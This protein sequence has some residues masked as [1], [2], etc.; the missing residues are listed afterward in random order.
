VG[1]RQCPEHK[2]NRIETNV[3]RSEPPSPLESPVHRLLPRSNAVVTYCSLFSGCWYQP[4]NKESI[5]H[6]VATALATVP[7]DSWWHSYLTSDSRQSRRAMGEDEGFRLANSTTLRLCPSS[8]PSGCLLRNSPP[9]RRQLPPCPQSST[10]CGPALPPTTVTLMMSE[11]RRRAE[12]FCKS[13][14]PRVPQVDSA[15]CPPQ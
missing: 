2:K 9:R 11:G 5:T 1:A 10:F 15:A 6:A 3:T 14:R 7:F 8:V 12:T 4:L 13:W